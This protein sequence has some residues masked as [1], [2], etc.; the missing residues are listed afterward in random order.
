MPVTLEIDSDV[1]VY[2]LEKILV[3]VQ[4]NKHIFLAQNI[5]WISSIIGLPQGLIIHIDNL[6]SREEKVAQKASTSPDGIEEPFVSATPRDL[7]EDWRANQTLES[8]KQF[9]EGSTRSR[10]IGQL[11]R[12]NQL[13]QT[14]AQLKKA[15]KVKR[16]QDTRRKSEDARNVRIQEIR[17]EVIRHLSME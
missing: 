3:Y 2:T 15:Q 11:S 17:T 4:N 12:V 8:A 5:R 6:W 10:T 7:T 14:K 9:I 1:I 13:P 16:L